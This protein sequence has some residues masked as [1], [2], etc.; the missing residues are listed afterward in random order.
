[1]AR[2]LLSVTIQSCLN[3]LCKFRP[4]QNRQ[5]LWSPSHTT[6]I[7]SNTATWYKL[8]VLNIGLKLKG[9]H[10]AV[11]Q[12]TKICCDFLIHISLQESN[13]Q[14][15]RPG[16]QRSLWCYKQD[17]VLV[18]RFLGCTFCWRLFQDMPYQ[19]NCW[20]Q[21]AIAHSKSSEVLK[22]FASSFI[23]IQQLLTKTTQFLN[24]VSILF[25]LLHHAFWRFT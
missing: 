2:K 11:I 7:Q 13:W 14:R 19:A 4:V 18:P 15:K 5:S 3:V 17:S 6:Q 8:Y 9:K 10:K 20:R 21:D 1:M 24:E 16:Q 12:L 23:E 22:Y 25:L